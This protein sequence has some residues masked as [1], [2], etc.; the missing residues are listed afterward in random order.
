MSR[1]IIRNYYMRIA[2]CLHSQ[3][4]FIPVLFHKYIIQKMS[5]TTKTATAATENPV[6]F[7]S[8]EIIVVLKAYN[9]DNEKALS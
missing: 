5:E 3:S 9:V 1:N 4:F 2:F 8:E 7:D 6:V